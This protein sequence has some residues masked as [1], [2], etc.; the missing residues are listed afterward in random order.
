MHVADYDLTGQT[1]WPAAQ[2]LAD[3]LAAHQNVLAGCTCTCELGAGLGLAGLFA[4]Q[5]CPVILTDH[6]EVVMRVM[7]KNA[8]LNQSNHSIRCV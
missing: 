2:M 5:I 6:N 7:S 8:A 1:I 3:Y 4:A